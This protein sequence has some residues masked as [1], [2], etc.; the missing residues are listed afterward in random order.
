MHWYLGVSA[1][2]LMAVLNFFFIDIPTGLSLLA[3]LAILAMIVLIDRR[4]GRQK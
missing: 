4:A 2:L 3:G 1:L